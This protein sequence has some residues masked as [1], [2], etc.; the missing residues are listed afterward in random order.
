MSHTYMNQGS[1][2]CKQIVL[3]GSKPVMSIALYSPGYKLLSAMGIAT[4]TFRSREN[5]STRCAGTV[6]AHRLRFDQL[7]CWLECRRTDRRKA[8]YESYLSA[9]CGTVTLGLCFVVIPVAFTVYHRYRGRRT[10]IC[11]D[12]DQIVEMEIKAARA[13][14][15]AAFGKPSLRVK[16]CSLWPRRKGCAES[17]LKV[18]WPSAR[19]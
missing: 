13:G 2:G 19:E 15:M 5:L 10:I 12:I 17:C 18:D 3:I 16:G 7:V 11:P 1:L 8:Q 14:I 4:S 6:L 9:H